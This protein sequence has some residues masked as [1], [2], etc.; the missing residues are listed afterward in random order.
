MKLKMLQVLCLLSL[1]WEKRY[2]TG[3]NIL[4]KV[5][6]TKN[7]KD[8]S[9]S[10]LIAPPPH[11]HKRKHTWFWCSDNCTINITRFCGNSR[12]FK[13]IRCIR[14]Q[15]CHYKTDGLFPHGA[16]L[17]SGQRARRICGAWWRCAST[18]GWRRAGCAP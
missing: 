15:M 16:Y 2:W 11:R 9:I 12:N 17:A 7:M 6:I 8:H 3:R 13:K 14:S 18:K 4:T 5:C 1:I 10:N